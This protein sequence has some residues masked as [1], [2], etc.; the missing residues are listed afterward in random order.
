[1]MNAITQSNR[2]TLLLTGVLSVALGSIS[3]PESVSAPRDC[4]LLLMSKSQT[5]K[6]LRS[7]V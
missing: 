1:M 5:A 3:V 6:K 2:N 4:Y 7:S